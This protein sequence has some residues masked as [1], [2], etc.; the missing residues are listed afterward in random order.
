MGSSVSSLV[1]G[2]R[3]TSRSKETS[4]RLRLAF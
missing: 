3:S 2:P 4:G 1:F